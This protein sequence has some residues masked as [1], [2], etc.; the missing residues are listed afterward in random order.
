M[1]NGLEPKHPVEAIVFDL[2]NVLIE[3]DPRHLF[4]KIFAGDE[5]G[6]ESFLS[7]VPTTEWNEQQDRGRPWSEAIAEAVARHPE[8]E[9]SI[10]AY[11]ERWGETIP[12]AMEATV[13]ILRQLKSLGFRLFALTNWSAETFHIAEERFSFLTWFEGIVVSGRERLM[14]P[15]PAIFKLIASRYHLRPAATVFIDDS[16]RNVEVANS[17]RFVGLHFRGPR[18]LRAQLRELGI[19]IPEAADE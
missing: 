14:K 3:W 6:M 1:A 11:R 15:E 10:R 2:G 9:S 16:V 18:Q 8:H 17:E 13:E 12:G 4:R 5:A 7:I 19:A